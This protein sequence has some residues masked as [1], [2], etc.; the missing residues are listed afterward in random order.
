ML[1]K[2]GNLVNTIPFYKFLL[3]N[4]KH[5][6]NFVKTIVTN[7]HLFFLL[8]LTTTTYSQQNLVP[9]PS[10]EVY[11]SCPDAAAEVYKATPWFDP[12]NASSDYFNACAPFVS[13]Y[14]VP[15]NTNNAGYEYA[16]DGNG[17]MGLAT[18]VGESQGVVNYREYIEVELT[19]ALKG[20]YNYCF[21]AYVSLADSSTYATNSIGV[22]FSNDTA[23]GAQQLPLPYSPQI[24]E[25]SIISTKNGWTKMSGTYTALGGEK[26]ITIGTFYADNNPLFQYQLAQ[27]TGAYATSYYYIDLVSL[28]L[29]SEEIQT[30]NVMTPNNDGNNDSWEVSNSTGMQ[31]FIYNRWGIMIY[32]QN[33]KQISWDG[34]TTSGEMCTDGVYY[35]ILETKEKNYKG[36]I[37]LIH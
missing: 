5:I 33:S 1:I 21:E 28:K 19:S 3:T 34:R 26:Y 31:V 9:N 24:V 14:D 22:Y 16:K 18:F 4:K 13:G 23:H 7:L 37:Q 25:D 15:D 6:L 36:F 2:N 20:G 32:E 29:C 11:S 35:Y 17:Y 8:M 12:T 27:D 30:P 10:F